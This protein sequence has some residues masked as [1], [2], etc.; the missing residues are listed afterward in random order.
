MRGSPFSIYHSLMSQVKS[1]ADGPMIVGAGVRL[2]LAEEQALN[3]MLRR[4]APDIDGM[5]MYRLGWAMED[6]FASPDASGGPYKFD[7]E[8]FTPICFEPNQGSY[9]FL[10]FEPP[11]AASAQLKG[12][13]PKRGTYNC[14]FHFIDPQTQ[15]PFN[16][17]VQMLEIIIP[18]IK[19]LN[20]IAMASYKGFQAT[21]TALRQR[22]IDRLKAQ[23]EKK[24]KDYEA[25]ADSV[26]EDKAPAFEGNPFSAPGPQGQK[27]SDLKPGEREVAEP[28]PLP[29]DFAFSVRSRKT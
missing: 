12:V 2:S 28:A 1:V 24:Q 19:Q 22:T 6:N 14:L 5:P 3:V 21:L 4:A 27:F 7:L 9:H 29:S 23:E 8:K 20:E 16:P 17:T 15:Q 11:S 13:D 10:V 25:Y 18:T 26:L